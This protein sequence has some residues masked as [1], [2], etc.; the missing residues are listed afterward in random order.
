M[1]RVS[2]GEMTPEKKNSLQSLEAILKS[3]SF[4]VILLGIGLLCWR[5]FE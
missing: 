5:V 4:G 1:K 2:L 3:V